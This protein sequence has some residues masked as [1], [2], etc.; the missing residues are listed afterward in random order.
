[1][2]RYHDYLLISLL[3][4]NDYRAVQISQPL[5]WRI[6]KAE[7]IDDTEEEIFDIHGILCGSDLPPV[8]TECVEKKKKKK[9]TNQ[10]GFL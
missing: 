6:T 4:A 9:E 7:N 2:N 1:M 10:M 3:Q 8:K 5:S